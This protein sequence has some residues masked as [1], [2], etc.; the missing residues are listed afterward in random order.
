MWN[1]SI[2]I[3]TNDSK[4]TREIKNKIFMAE[5]AFKKES[6]RYEYGFNFK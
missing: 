6:F 3:M 5:A 4:C 1:V 2:I